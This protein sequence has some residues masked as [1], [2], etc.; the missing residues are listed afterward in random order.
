MREISPAIGVS[1]DDWVKRLP[2]EAR[3]IV[4]EIRS[5]KQAG[6]RQGPAATLI[7]R[8][9]I[10][11]KPMRDK[12]LD[13][14]AALVDENYAGRAEMCLQFAALLQRA[15]S[16][17]NFPSRAAAG[18]AI[19]YGAKGEE[20]WRWQHAWVRIGNEVID[21]NVDCLAENPLV[22]K[23]VSV[24]PYWGPIAEVP[25]D[26]RL[27]DEQRTPPPDVDVDDIWWPELRDWL[28]KEFLNSGLGKA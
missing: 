15:L 20:I 18:T 10:M 6:T 24:A 23:A 14:V 26:R 1:V 4:E 16:H 17:L 9:A 11:T 22:P 19:Y 13:A 27:R 8:S 2:A 28:D 3:L 12:L 25:A 7:D 21:G 5:Q